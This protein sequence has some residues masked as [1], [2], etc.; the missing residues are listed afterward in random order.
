MALGTQPQARGKMLD[1]EQYIDHQLRRTRNQIKKVDVLSAALMLITVTLGILFLEVVLDHALAL[2]IWVR[3]IILFVGGGLGIAYAAFRIVRPLAASVNGMYAAKTIELSEPEFKNGLI[4]YLALRKDRENL[5]K[6]FLAAIEAKAVSQL[7]KV[8]V[9]GVVNQRRVLKTAYALSAIVVLFCIYAMLTPKPIWDSAKRAF[10]ADIAP[11]TDTRLLNLEPGSNDAL[12]KVVAGSHVPFS[13]EVEGKRPEKVVLHYSIDG[14]DFF[15]EQEVAPG[16][17]YYDKWQTTLRNVQRSVDYYMTGGDARTK[18]YN[19]EVLPAPLVTGVSLDYDFPAYTGVA[20]RAGVDG[21]SIDVIE[22]TMVTV[23]AKTSEPAVDGKLNLVGK[24]LS[25]NMAPKAD[26]AQEIVGKFL[27][28]ENGSYTVTFRTSALQPN[29][30]PVVYEIR[31]RKDLPPTAKIVKPSSTIKLPA[32]G[33]VTVV[34]EATDDF[35]IKEV[36]LPIYEGTNRRGYLDLKIP[37]G[38]PRKLTGSFDLDLLKLDTPPRPG[39]RLQYWLTV[40]DN[41]EPQPNK[42]E[43]SK[44][45]IEVIEP[46]KKEELAKLDQAAQREKQEADEANKAQQRQGQQEEVAQNGDA[47]NRPDADGQGNPAGDRQ[48][49]DA[50]RADDKNQV[51]MNDR[52]Q[53]K[54]GQAGDANIREQPQEP[55][56][57]AEQPTERDLQKLKNLER[58][59]QGKPRDGGQPPASKANPNESPAANQGE[60]SPRDGNPPD[61]KPAGEGGVSKP[62][63][64]NMTPPDNSGGRSEAKQG[65][66]PQGDQNPSNDVSRAPSGETPSQPQKPERGNPQKPN[67]ESSK[68]GA[69]GAKGANEPNSQQKP[70]KNAEA[71]K[72]GTSANGTNEKAGPEGAGSEGAQPSKDGMDQKN[73]PKNVGPGQPNAASTGARTPANP[74]PSKPNKPEK[75]DGTNSTANP[76]GGTDQATGR[77]STAT[78]P[79]KPEMGRKPSGNAKESSQADAGGSK[80]N[81]PPEGTPGANASPEKPMEKNAN[82][83][84]KD[85]GDAG[86]QKPKDGSQTGQGADGQSGN[87]SP[88]GQKPDAAKPMKPDPTSGGTEKPATNS[89]EPGQ[90]SEGQPGAKKKADP[91]TA[92]GDSGSATP[93]SPSSATGEKPGDNSAASQKPASEA[94]GVMKPDASSGAAQKPDGGTPADKPSGEPSAKNGA[95]DGKSKATDGGMKPEKTGASPKGANG[96]PGAQEKGTEGEKASETGENGE[97]GG[98]SKKSDGEKS[99]QAGTNG[100]K[101]GSMAKEGSAGKAGTESPDGKQATPTGSNKPGD[102]AGGGPNPE[103]SSTGKPGEPGAGKSPMDDKAAPTG[104]GDGKPASQ[105]PGAAPDGGQADAQRQKMGNGAGE[106]PAKNGE[107]NPSGEPTPGGEKGQA[108][109]V[110]KQAGAKGSQANTPPRPG[111][112]NAPGTPDPNAVPDS[113]TPKAKPGTVPEGATGGQPIPEKPDSDANDAA[114]TKSGTPDSKTIASK[115]PAKDKPD[116]ST[117]FDPTQKGKILPPNPNRPAETMPIQPGDGN[118]EGSDQGSDNGGKSPSADQTT[119]GKGDKPSSKRDGT[120]PAGDNSSRDTTGSDPSKPGSNPSSEG[121]TPGGEGQGSK[122]GEKGSDS[123]PGDSGQ[124]SK[125]GGAGEGS[126]PGGSGQGSKPGGAGEGSKPGD[127]GAGGQAAQ[128][129]RGTPSGAASQPGGSQVGKGGQ[130]GGQAPTGSKGDR[131]GTDPGKGGDPSPMKNAPKGAGPGNK[132]TGGGE[133]GPGSKPGM[134]KEDKSTPLPDASGQVPQNP[135]GSIAPDTQGANLVIRT[136]QDLLKENKVTPEVEKQFDMTRGEMEQFVKKFEKGKPRPAAGPGREIKVNGETAERTFDPNR[137]APENLPNVAVSNRND[138][139]G[140]DSR[141]DDLHSLSEGSQVAAPRAL[142]SRYD[143][144]RSSIGRTTIVPRRQVAPPATK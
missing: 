122:P 17:N 22:G 95:G 54:D 94:P 33:K 136:I 128:T 7:T 4:N 109:S 35:G 124:G 66:R 111:D 36:F 143:A 81:V 55:G 53:P 48:Q 20:D 11:P 25:F 52:A 102:Q 58:M 47:D 86:R 104:A 73:S 144:Y 10:L 115:N 1:Y 14:G 140:Q 16:K 82:G 93:P 106:K 132:G 50:N 137:K 72:D 24:D 92:G 19:I 96:E 8:D 21:G 91:A 63:P 46:A 69:N 6:S 34:V 120:K 3:R 88:A 61:S 98:G 119:P 116:A 138:R 45:E 141:T 67:G 134:P 51:A 78:A 2:S 26:D 60:Q 107:G 135:D 83:S 43:T 27:V 112:P 76:A 65:D 31:A 77:D 101:P 123:K 75:D 49:G 41:R 90:G 30:E 62:D 37:P 97:P 118:K 110:T 59:L 117:G 15:A 32:N 80:S 130:P 87:K 126:K 71:S 74:T 99:S 38:S 23:H 12:T 133:D 57:G 13:V 113:M 108:P 18:T 105:K 40:R 103:S 125:P 79:V 64:R 5:P 139:S 131:S 56:A 70:E 127:S 121:N 29:P 89:A 85:G 84:S 142:R 114:E 100:E 39:T 28:T 42:V 129:G 9:E 44:Y 68:P